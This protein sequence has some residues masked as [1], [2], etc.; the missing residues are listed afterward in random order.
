MQSAARSVDLDPSSAV[1][2]L[3]L[4]RA[5]I[6]VGSIDAARD[7]LV[8][9][10]ALDPENEEIQEEMKY[11]RTLLDRRGRVSTPTVV[12]YHTDHSPSLRSS[13][14]FTRRS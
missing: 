13:L 10:G 1:A 4:G 8:K 12:Y 6:H 3:T 7:T 11:L 9:A 2:H 5:Q 14:L